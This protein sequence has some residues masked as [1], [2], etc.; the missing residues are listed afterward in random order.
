VLHDLFLFGGM[1]LYV[2]LCLRGKYKLIIGFALWTCLIGMFPRTVPFNP[3][4]GFA[5]PSIM[6][7]VLDVWLV[8]AVVSGQSLSDIEIFPN[9]WVMYESII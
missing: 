2:I 7:Q 8:M 5:P 6:H 9:C 4:P 1:C 3:D